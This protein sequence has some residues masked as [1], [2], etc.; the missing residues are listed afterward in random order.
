MKKTLALLAAAA[1]S[2]PA[3]AQSQAQ[4][5]DT[6]TI[7]GLFDVSAGASRTGEGTTLPG[8]GVPTA[9]S[10]RIYRVDSGLGFG[11]RLGFRGV[12]DMGG[13][14]RA[15]F[16]L[17]MGLALDTGGQNQ[18]GLTYGR[19][20]FVGVG[21]RGWTLSAGRQY[22]PLNNSIANSEVLLGG[23]WGNVTAQA[24]GTYESIGST[25]ASGTFQMA[26]RA[27]N[28]V[29]L[30]VTT[31]RLTTN[32][33][34]AAGDENTRGTGRMA[35]LGLTYAGGPLRLDASYMRLRQNVEQIGAAAVP[36]WTTLWMA[37]GSYD[38]KF[39]KLHAGAF[40]FRAAEN[41]AG[42]SAVNTLGAAGAAAQA[43]GWD[44]QRLYWISAG[45]PVGK[46][47]V[48]A[49][50]ARQS[51]AYGGLPDGRATILALAYEHLLSKRTSLYGSYGR[52]GNNA[53]AR[54]PLYGAI[55]QVGP[56]GFGSDPS[57]LSAG[58]IH[59]F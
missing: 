26:A 4:V 14:L 58:I 8:S 7:Y 13:G 49:Q 53:Y 21:G 20:A 16:T 33:M 24:V 44:R 34:A 39:V 45:V 56:N 28:S 23:S 3:Q 2:V 10:A 36:E 47:I 43:Y 52:V 48:K 15:L 17:E 29:L 25:A 1:C 57:A 55:P 19:Q 9:A 54:T 30:S 18:G 35:N 42:Y 40:E 51:Y 37:G 38:L 22:T 46:G 5:Q 27:N 32:L 6:V 11:S 59:R 41:K 12:E 31:G 50:V